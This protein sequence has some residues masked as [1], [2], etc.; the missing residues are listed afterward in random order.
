MKIY[1]YNEFINETSTSEFFELKEPKNDDD[2]TNGIKL[3]LKEYSHRN[4][5]L[6][7]VKSWLEENNRDIINSWLKSENINTLNDLEVYCGKL[8][9]KL[10]NGKGKTRQE[11]K[12]E[13]DNR[14]SHNTLSNIENIAL[15][16]EDEM[17]QRIKDEYGK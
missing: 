1:K 9:T 15:L 4:M 8:Q 2:V 11:I 16:S 12:K 14:K 13:I 10:R 3:I 5:A 17:Q 6:I 7:Q